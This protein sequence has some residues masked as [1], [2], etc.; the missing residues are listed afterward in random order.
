MTGPPINQNSDEWRRLRAA[1]LERIDTLR[2]DLE[3]PHGFME[4]AL[5]RGEI[6]GLR[7]L[8]KQVDVKPPEQIDGEDYISHQPPLDEG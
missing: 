4:T 5:F 2:E 3:A 7:W 1:L 8:I 6:R